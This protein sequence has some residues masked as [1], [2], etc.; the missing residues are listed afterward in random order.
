MCFPKVEERVRVSKM[1]ETQAIKAVIQTE[2]DISG[3]FCIENNFL[4]YNELLQYL[5]KK[6]SFLDPGIV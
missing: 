5:A 1:Y 4:H 3:N 6:K 2:G